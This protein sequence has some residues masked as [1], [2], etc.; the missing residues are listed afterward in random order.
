MLSA[1]E[2]Y[3]ASK[4][5]GREAAIVPLLEETWGTAIH[6]VA[7]QP[8]KAEEG[9]IVF[10]ANHPAGKRLYVELERGVVE[11]VTHDRFQ[12]GVIEYLERHL[13][14]SE[15]DRERISAVLARAKTS[16]RLS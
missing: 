12:P 8:E 4:N 15:N 1:F 5:I 7:D 16:S 13:P 6:S 14:L 2:R 9:V 10:V 3:L 11:V